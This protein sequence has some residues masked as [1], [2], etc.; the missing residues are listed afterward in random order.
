[1][2]LPR[3]LVAEP[4][5]AIANALK[6]FLQGWAEVQVAHDVDEARQLVSEARPEVVI[7]A[8]TETFDGEQL[9]RHVRTVAPDIAMI[10]MYPSIDWELAPGRAQAARADGFLV[11]PLKKHHLLGMVQAVARLNRLAV[12]LRELKT[13]FEQLKRVGGR[14]T[15]SGPATAASEPDEAFFKKYMLLEIKRSKRYQYPVSMLMVSLD[16]LTTHLGTLAPKFQRAE[17]RSEALA[18]LLVLLRDIDVALPLP[19]DRFLVFLPH[20]PPSGCAVVANRVVDRLSKLDS[21][22]GGAVSVGVASF[23]PQRTPKEPVGFGTLVREA[24]EA[25]KKAQ[26]EGGNRFWPPEIQ[27]VPKK[28][29]NRISMG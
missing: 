17:I 16:Q 18:A 22:P 13:Q 25:M 4:A 20:T 8:V 19:L 5:V 15:F 11:A 24:T 29:R 14:L 23:D 1:M 2:S 6:K 7:A 28:K 12:Q 10:L 26:S 9:L 21:F 3:I 27:Q